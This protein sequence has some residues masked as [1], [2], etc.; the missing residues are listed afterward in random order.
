ALEL[1]T[2]ANGKP[3][4]EDLTVRI[5]I[6]FDRG[7]PNSS[8][9]AL[10]LLDELKQLRPLTW[11]E[12]FVLAKLYD[13]IGDWTS[14]RAE[15]LSLLTQPKADPIIY[16]TFIKMLL[17]HGSPDDALTWLKSLESLGN[18][19]KTELTFLAA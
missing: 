18:Q 19:D 16:T 12:R 15:M 17:Q 7:D 13:R 4:I 6:L 14:A 8:R 9:Q 11:Q 5:T 1:L 2:P 10:R 3:T